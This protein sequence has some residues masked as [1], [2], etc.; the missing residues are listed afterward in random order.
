MSEK[1]IKSRQRVAAHGEVFTSEREVNAMLDLVKSETERIDSR[2]LE[3]ACGEGNF[4]IEILRRKLA[5]VKDKYGKRESDYEKASII[6][7]TSIYGVELLEDNAIVCRNRLYSYWCEQ[8]LLNCPNSIRDEVRKAAKYILQKNILVGDALSLKLVDSAQKPLND[9][10][11]FAE[12]TFV[13]GTKVKRRDYRLDVILK[14]EDDFE[15]LKSK[16]KV[17][18]QN[19]LFGD[20]DDNDTNSFD[21]YSTDPVTHEIIPKPIKEYPPVDYWEVQNNG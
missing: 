7:L 21:L 6:T 10:I 15:Q 2:F 3:P 8:Y 9:P 17:A 1:Q 20:E 16:K 13:M 18:I 11:V 4:L 19:S 5:V 12:W 14:A